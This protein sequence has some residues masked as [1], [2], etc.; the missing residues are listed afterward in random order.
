MT[1]R[2]APSSSVYDLNVVLTHLRSC[3][4]VTAAILGGIMCFKND[5]AEQYFD[6]Q[7]FL[8]T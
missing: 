2:R 5:F 1:D 4:A 8:P 7:T 6:S 3:A